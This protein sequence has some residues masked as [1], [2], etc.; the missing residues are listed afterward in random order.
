LHA[1]EEQFRRAIQDAPIPV[2]MYAED[3]QVLQISRTWTELTGY[4]PEDIPTFDAWLNRAYGLGAE[5]VRAHMHQLFRGDT[6]R[7]EAALDVITRAGECRHWSFSASAP[8]LL[9]DGRRFI[10]GMALDI[11]E[12]RL[13]E[14]ALRQS[15]ERLRLIV[16][17]AREYAIFSMDLERR[18]TIWSTGAE[19]ILGYG[20][21]EVIGQSGDLIFTPEDRADGAPE[22]EA[23]QALAE[24]RASDE[25]WHVRKGGSHFWGSGVM[26]AMRD[27]RG[28]AIGLLK[29]FRDETAARDAKL[30]LEESLST[31]ERARSE[32]E[33]AAREKD[34]FLAV[35]SHELR[36]PLTP[37]ILAVRTL[38]SDKALPHT[39]CDA[40]TMIQRNVHL[41]TQ[42]LDDLLDVTRISRVK[43]EL[44]REPIDLHAAIMRAVQVSSPDMES[45][46]QRLALELA[47]SEHWLVG[48]AKRLQQVFW[49]LLKNASK[50]T[51]EGGEIEIR[52]ANDSGRIVV[53][54]RDTG[55]GFEPEAAERIF[56]AFEQANRSITRD[57][58]GIGLGL[59]IAKAS[60]E[61]HGGTIRAKSAGGGQGATFTVE[62]PCEEKRADSQINDQAEL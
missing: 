52:S 61:A 4:T 6:R 59:A 28:Q 54:V 1:G 33:V 21:E 56:K 29:I 50:F 27:D 45:K 47:A 7:M 62:L 34:H 3:G 14:Q 2:I 48:D 12:G 41:Q 24:G 20:Q 55:I 37:V 19:S 17:N 15:E 57:F 44:V 51:P 16:E 18:I 39:F 26:T 46:S 35:L 58:G 9:N 31:V 22:R 53:D 11:T 13:V 30:A 10:V 23:A 36:T 5:A 40:L 43:M 38:L 8:G 25:R 32:A 42:L 60:V 49:N